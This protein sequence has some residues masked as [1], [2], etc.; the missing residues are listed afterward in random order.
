M[1][2][3][4]RLDDQQWAVIASLLPTN[5][6]DAHRTD[7]RWVIQWDHPR[8][9]IGLPMAG[10]SSLLRTSDNRLQS[11]PSLVSQRNMAAAV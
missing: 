3:E 9:V 10:L 2:G 11:L 7:D 4:F 8:P 1:A 6:P 5:Q